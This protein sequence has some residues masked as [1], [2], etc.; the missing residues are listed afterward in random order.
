MSKILTEDIIPALKEKINGKERDTGHPI[1]TFYKYNDGSRFPII[2]YDKIELPDP[3]PVGY[4]LY[5]KAG[6]DFTTYTNSYGSSVRIN[7]IKYETLL[8]TIGTYTG[9]NLSYIPPYI[10]HKDSL[11]MIIYSPDSEGTPKWEF[12]GGTFYITGSEI[13]PRGITSTNIDFTNYNTN[14]PVQVGNWTNGRP[15]Y[16][17]LFKGNLNTGGSYNIDISRLGVGQV[18]SISGTLHSSY[19]A[20]Y[21]L[22]AYASANNFS[23]AGVKDDGTVLNI[24]YATTPYNSQPY[25]VILEYTKAS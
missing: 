1:Y 18:V 16:R 19:G 13:A 17:S 10:V 24:I 21:P 7:R 25:V 15:I 8:N 14:I 23:S 2:I 12:L 6:E 5:L 3:I 11:C 4:T 22:G 20:T 9:A